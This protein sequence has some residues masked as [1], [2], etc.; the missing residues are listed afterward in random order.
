MKQSVQSKLFYYFL[1]IIIL[2]LAVAGVIIEEVVVSVRMDL[3][4]NDLLR[5]LR[6]VEWMVHSLPKPITPAAYH[7]MAGQLGA[8]LAVRVSFIDDKGWVIGDSAVLP[9]DL[10]SIANHRDRPEVAEALIHGVGSATRSSTT[11][12][13]DLFY[14]AYAIRQEDQAM[15][16]RLARPLQDLQDEIASLRG[17]VFFPALFAAMLAILMSRLAA[18]LFTRPL[19]GL[20]KQAKLIS[21]QQSNSRLVTDAQDEV[22]GL[23]TSFNLVLNQ[24]EEVMASVSL[25]RDRL[26]IILEGILDG[27]IAVDRAGQ[28]LLVNQAAM[29]L[30][31]LGTFPSACNLSEL[32]SGDQ[33]AGLVPPC[34]DDVCRKEITL[35]GRDNKQLLVT[36]T[37]TANGQGC[38]LVLRDITEKNRLQQV[39]RDF[40]ASASHELRTPVSIIRLNA[41]TLIDGGN[42]PEEVNFLVEAIYRHSLR[43]S[44]LITHLLDLSRL[45][46]GNYPLRCQSFLLLPVTQQVAESLHPWLES[47]EITLINRIETDLTLFADPSAVEQI[48]LNL[49]SN[50]I[51]YTPVRSRIVL[52]AKPQHKNEMMIAVEDNGEGIPEEHYPRLFGRFYRVDPSRSREMGGSGLGLTIVKHLVEVM[53]GGVGVTSVQPSGCCFWFTLPITDGCLW[54]DLC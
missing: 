1:T 41:E 49:V 21:G 34:L 44:Q 9:E 46:S 31:G 22:G 42:E 20:V 2:S 11:V 17:L 51:R 25:E 53:G 47:R 13:T 52:W 19:R 48:L 7:E 54:H 39:Q 6:T 16:V 43:M 10:H 50:A 36:A 23:A 37:C 18:R 45:E 5:H 4:R 14:L 24:L 35:P 26:K 27:V 3:I 12:N 8:I 33:L 38:I 15:V 32:I 29:S 40:I 30:F 28:I